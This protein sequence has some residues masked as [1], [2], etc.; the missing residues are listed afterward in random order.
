M[1]W[2]G[3]IVLKWKQEEEITKK[4]TAM[5]SCGELDSEDDPNQI[6][7]LT[8]GRYVVKTNLLIVNSLV[9]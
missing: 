9:I 8:F 6:V 7:L 3:V 2:S 5:Y 4:Y 1:R